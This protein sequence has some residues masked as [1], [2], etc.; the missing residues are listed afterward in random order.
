MQGDVTSA[1]HQAVKVGT[2]GSQTGGIQQRRLSDSNLAS[3]LPDQLAGLEDFGNLSAVQIR[4]VLKEQH[5][6]DLI[7]SV[8]FIHFWA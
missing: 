2:Q 5:I 6:L 1:L 3:L 7:T 4:D 8:S